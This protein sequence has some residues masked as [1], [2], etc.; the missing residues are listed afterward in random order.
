MPECPK[1]GDEMETKGGKW[2]HNLAVKT[3]LFKPTRQKM[4][5]CKQCGYIEF[6]LKRV[7]GSTIFL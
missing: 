2:D 4:H 3:G 6:Y 5:I 7:L 1:C